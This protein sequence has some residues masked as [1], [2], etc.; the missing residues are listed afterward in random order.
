MQ[1]EF[2]ADMR[3]RSRQHNCDELG[4]FFGDPVCMK[5]ALVKSYNFSSASARVSELLV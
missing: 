3:H 1:N 4:E 2:T 5:T